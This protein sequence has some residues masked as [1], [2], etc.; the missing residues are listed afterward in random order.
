M[1]RGP[2]VSS[3]SSNWAISYSLSEYQL[4]LIPIESDTGGCGGKSPRHLSE[5]LRDKC[6][7]LRELVARLVKQ[8]AA[9]MVS[10]F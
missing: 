1:E 8:I 10:V 6:M 4:L 3:C 7:D 2:E 5:G 9:A